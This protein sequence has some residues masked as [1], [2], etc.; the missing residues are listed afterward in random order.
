MN[1][2]SFVLTELPDELFQKVQRIF[3]FGS[4]SAG[5]ATPNSDIDIFF[6]VVGTANEIKLLKR[7]IITSIDHF[8]LSNEGLLFKLQGI[9][10]DIS[11]QV[12]KVEEGD[13]YASIVENSI[14]LYGP[15]QAKVTG[16][17]PHLI[18]YWEK[19]GRN[20]GAFLNKLYGYNVG[21]RHYS[22]LLEKIK[23]VKI[24]KSAILFPL[25]QKNKVQ[26][27]L[28]EYDVQYHVISVAI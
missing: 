13:L 6:D 16:G 19:V 9:T 23:G 26:Q 17:D 22:G 27:L 11:P 21:N 18:L 2:V 24:G 25:V 1:V 3:L 4:V 14:E 12:G 20:R 15:F 5:T 28:E 10:N 7:Q 8:Q